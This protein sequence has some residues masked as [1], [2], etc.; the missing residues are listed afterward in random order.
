M[1]FRLLS[2][3][4]LLFVSLSGLAI[5]PAL[6]QVELAKGRSAYL[7]CTL[8]VGRKD[9]PHRRAFVVADR[10]ELMARFKSA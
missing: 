4:A 1:L 6:W 7:F 10:A 9:M 8:H 2:S 3:L 5:T